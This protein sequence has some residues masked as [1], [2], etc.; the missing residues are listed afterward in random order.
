MGVIAARGGLPKPVAWEISAPLWRRGESLQRSLVSGLFRRRKPQLDPQSRRIIRYFD[1]RTM[2][3][4]NGCNEA[5]TETTARAV[6]TML[7]PIKAFQ[8]VLAFIGRNSGTVIGNGH[9]RAAGTAA[10]LDH[11]SVIVAAVLDRVVDEI[12]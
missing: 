6:T 7:Q 11:H 12:G 2:E 10:H 9:D 3:I 8:H 1:L 5:Q 4:G